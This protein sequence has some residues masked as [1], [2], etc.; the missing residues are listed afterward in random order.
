[1][2]ITGGA[3]AFAVSSDD[4]TPLA[5][6]CGCYVPAAP[7][8]FE[9]PDEGLARVLVRIYSSAAQAAERTF[10]WLLVA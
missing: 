10:T 4:L 9:D 3:A 6:Y 1:V 2:S 7:G 8:F 5:G